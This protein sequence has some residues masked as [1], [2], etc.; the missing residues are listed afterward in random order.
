MFSCAP[1]PVGCVPCFINSIPNKHLTPCYEWMRES[2]PWFAWLILR[3]IRQNQRRACV[4]P[5]SMRLWVAGRDV[6]CFGLSNQ[7]GN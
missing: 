5:G 6:N 7:L 1:E 4:A 3:Y 2:K